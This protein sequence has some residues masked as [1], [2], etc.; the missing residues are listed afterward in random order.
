MLGCKTTKKRKK[1]KVNP[2]GKNNP[3]LKEVILRIIHVKISDKICQ[4]NSK[5]Y[6]FKKCLDKIVMTSKKKNIS[7]YL[8]GWTDKSFKFVVSAAKVAVG[9]GKARW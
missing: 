1:R 5:T 6:L 8:Q 4:F 7:F 3:K 9:Q 2:R